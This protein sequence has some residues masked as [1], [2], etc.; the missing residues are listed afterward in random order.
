ML[1]N[2]HIFISYLNKK[3]EAIVSSKYKLLFLVF[4]HLFIENNL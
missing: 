3:K 1:F 4:Y 2:F